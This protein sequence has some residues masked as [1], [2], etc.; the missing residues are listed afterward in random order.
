LEAS[1]AEADT[2]YNVAAISQQ[3]E[4]AAEV[5]KQKTADRAALLEHRAELEVQRQADLE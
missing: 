5:A 1:F 4:N 2:Q 3:N